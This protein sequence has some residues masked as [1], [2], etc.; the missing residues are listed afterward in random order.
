MA[1]NAGINYGR[2]VQRRMKES[3][4]QFMEKKGI[5]KWFQRDNLIIL[6]LSGVLLLI[7]ALPTK[8]TSKDTRQQDNAQTGKTVA[9]DDADTSSPGSAMALRETDADSYAAQLELRLAKTLAGMSGVGKVN[10]M[11]TLQSSEELVVEKD[12]PLTRSNT[13]ET[14]SEGGSRSVYQTDSQETTVYRSS[15]SDSEPYVV[16]TLTPKVEGVVVVAEGAGNGET[17]RNITEAV[18]ALFGIE[19]HKIKVLRMGSAGNTQN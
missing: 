14:D 16:K 8:E 13:T 11:I 7:I 19:A 9:A 10:V 18:E 2:K 5:Q 1:G 15:G 3:W 6:I 17:S 4:K 12:Q